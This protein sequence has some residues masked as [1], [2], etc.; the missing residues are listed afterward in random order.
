MTANVGSAERMV[1]FIIGAV[2]LALG[3][4]A[5]SH[6]YVQVAF[7]AAGTIAVISAAVRFCPVWSLLG[8]NTCSR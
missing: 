5:P 3:F 1:R 6:P 8:I 4:F 2:L 7:L